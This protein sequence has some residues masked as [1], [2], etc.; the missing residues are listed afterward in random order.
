MLGL[1]HYKIMS[2]I[3]NSKVYDIDC[4][5]CTWNEEKFVYDIYGPIHVDLCWAK[6]YGNMLG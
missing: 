1:C 5:G 3:Q 6:P 4:L 2:Q